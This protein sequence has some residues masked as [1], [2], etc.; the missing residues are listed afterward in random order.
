ML[1]LKTLGV[2]LIISGFGSYGLMGARRLDKRVHQIRNIRLAM[3]FLEKEITYLHTPLTTALARA[4]QSIPYPASMLF[5]HCARSL[6]DRQG[7]TFTEAWRASLEQLAR[8]SELKKEDLELLQSV[9][10]QLGMSGA[11]DQQRFFRYIEEQLK[12]QEDKSRH[13]LESGRKIR[14]YGGFIL[15]STVVLLL[16]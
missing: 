9:A 4:A 14:A 5:S 3:A 10:S 13:E 2:V 6:Q 15:G 7:A 1:G 8:V 12:I 16:F 11:D